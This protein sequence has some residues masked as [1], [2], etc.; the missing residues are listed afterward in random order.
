MER[1]AKVNLSIPFSFFED[2]E[3]DEKKRGALFLF[4]SFFLW[5]Y[6]LNLGIGL[7]P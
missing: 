6:S 4:F 1:A 3:R 5:R 7:P 2:R